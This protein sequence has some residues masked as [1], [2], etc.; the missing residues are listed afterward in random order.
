[1]VVMVTIEMVVVMMRVVVGG[2]GDM[3]DI[4]RHQRT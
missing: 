4:L 1:M 3:D 2:N